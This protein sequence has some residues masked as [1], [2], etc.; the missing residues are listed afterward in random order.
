MKPYISYELIKDKF[1]FILFLR[2]D[3]TV[4]SVAGG[5]FKYDSPGSLLDYRRGMSLTDYWIWPISHFSLGYDHQPLL[6]KESFIK[7][8]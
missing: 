8:R 6:H 5:I 2:H 1:T 4:I 7:M 3:Y